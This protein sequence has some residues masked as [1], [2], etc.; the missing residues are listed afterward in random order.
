MAEEIPT[1]IFIFTKELIFL[2]ELV[3]G[4]H[5][6][7]LLELTE[8]QPFHIED[9]GTFIDGWDIHAIHRAV[10]Y[11]TNCALL[12]YFKCERCQTRLFKLR[13][14]LEHLIT[15]GNFNLYEELL[16]QED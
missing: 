10:T 9:L 1:F 3:S 8:K 7:I 4:K 11:G 12:V 2:G 14:A 13:P 15:C 16:S 6:C 5:Q